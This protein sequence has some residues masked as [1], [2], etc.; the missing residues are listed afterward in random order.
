MNNQETIESLYDN[1]V[2]LD[3][4]A[5]ELDPETNRKIDEQRA[6]IVQQLRDLGETL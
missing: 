1:L 5:G 6:K 3:E 2:H 4:I